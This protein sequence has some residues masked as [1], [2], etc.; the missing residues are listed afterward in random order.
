MPN[1]PNSALTW[2]WTE[3]IDNQFLIQTCCQNVSIF[4][5]V[6][7]KGIPKFCLYQRPKAF[8]FLNI[9]FYCIYAVLAYIFYHTFYGST[10]IFLEWK[11]TRD[12]I[13]SYHKTLNEPVKTFR[14]CV[15]FFNMSKRV[16]ALLWR[17]KEDKYMKTY[18]PFEVRCRL[19]ASDFAQCIY[20][21][22][23]ILYKCI[24]ATVNNVLRLSL[25]ISLL[26]IQPFIIKIFLYLKPLKMT[27]LA[28]QRTEPCSGPT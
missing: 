13:K 19:Y 20:F 25:Y 10:C 6:I 7:S 1:M 3:L 24:C 5:N 26:Y 11:K 28:F 8:N 23:Y 9:P 2:P 27:C 21:T 12:V 16:I 4:R 15:P 18:W 17:G 22:I 14:V